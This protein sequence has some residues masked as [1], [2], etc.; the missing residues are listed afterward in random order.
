MRSLAF[1][2]KKFIFISKTP[3][4]SQLYKFISENTKVK[5]LFVV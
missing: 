3:K 1:E 4:T 5:L 2:E